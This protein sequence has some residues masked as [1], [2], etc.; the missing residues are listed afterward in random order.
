MW[1]QVL[2]GGYNVTVSDGGKASELQAYFGKGGGVS[3]KYKR[4]NQIRTR[5]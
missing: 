3:I 1:Y 5:W 4:K 2:S